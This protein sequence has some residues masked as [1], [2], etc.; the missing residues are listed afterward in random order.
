MPSGKQPLDAIG[1]RHPTGEGRRIPTR[2][3]IL[4]FEM[5]TICPQ[6]PKHGYVS[7]LNGTM[8][9]SLGR[10]Y[11]APCSYPSPIT[12]GVKLLT[13]VGNPS[14]TTRTCG[15]AGMFK[16]SARINH[17]LGPPRCDLLQRPDDRLLQVIS[18][19]NVADHPSNIIEINII[20]ICP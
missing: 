18:D 6:T 10:L 2:P 15:H 16:R 3:Q 11:S 13:G 4:R 9:L 20:L 1:K 17:S 19:R 8:Q 7:P 14:V 5:S 12:G